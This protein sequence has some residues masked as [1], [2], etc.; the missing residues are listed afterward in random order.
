MRPTRIVA[1]LLSLFLAATLPL[2]SLSG[3]QAADRHASVSEKAGTK[4]TIN[5]AANGSTSFKL[6]GKIKPAAKNKKAVL[7]RA[8]KLRG[9]YAKMRV[10]RTNKRGAYAFTGLKKEGYYRVRIGTTKSRAIHVCKG[11]CG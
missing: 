5:F 8:N 1:T 4:V 11:A 3:A 2:V 7:L 9:H 6:Y 10:T